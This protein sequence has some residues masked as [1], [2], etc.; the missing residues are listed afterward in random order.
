VFDAFN[1]G[2]QKF[3]QSGAWRVWVDEVAF[4]AERIGC[5]G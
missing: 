3:Q 1:I 5:E 2:F 4:D